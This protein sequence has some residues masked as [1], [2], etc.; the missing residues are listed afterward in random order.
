V[1]ST[2]AAVV[3]TATGQNYVLTFAA[4]VLP[5]A[6]ALVWLASQFGDEL[7][8]AKGREA[9]ALHEE[10]VQRGGR[11]RALAHCRCHGWVILVTQD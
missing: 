6:A 4:A 5:P 9:E 8:G 7:W 10:E 3:F 2:V 11:R 1:G